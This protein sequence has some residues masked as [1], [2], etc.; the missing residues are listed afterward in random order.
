MLFGI[1]S[2]PEHFQRQM[3]EI[4]DNLSG[5][6]CLMDDIIIHGKNQQEHKERLLATIQ[7]L[8][9]AGVTLNQEKCQFGK[10]T[11]NYLGHIISADNISPHSNKVKAVANMKTPTSTTELL[12]FLG[13]VNQM[14]KFTP[15]ITELSKPLHELLNKWSTWLWGPSQVSAFQKLKAA[16]TLPTVLAWYDLSADTK[17]LQIPLPLFSVPYCSRKQTEVSGNQ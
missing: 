16:L 14:G 6:L 7:R 13:M 12:H 15:E 10:S 17:P 8:Q 11:F 3:N 9:A 4:L 2:T 5:V 1:S